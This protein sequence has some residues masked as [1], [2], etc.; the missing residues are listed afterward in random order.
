MMVA[1]LTMA[2]SLTA[3]TEAKKE[4]KS[5]S[6]NLVEK[7]KIV[8]TICI[9]TMGTVKK[10]LL[11]AMID[12]IR[13]HYPKCRFVKN[14]PLPKSAITK[15]RNDHVRYISN[16]LN[17]YLAQYKSDTTIV[18]GLT[19][20]DIGKD[21]FRNRPHS[22][23]MGEAGGFNVPVAVFSSYRPKNNKQLFSVILHEVGHTQ[24]LRHC[25]NTKCMMQNAN[26]GNPFAKTNHF[27][28]KCKK[29]MQNRGWKL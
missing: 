2:L 1:I 14:I 21:N 6:Q 9:Y 8:P 22:G 25:P 29:H 13:N 10:D 5:T 27:C 18:I 17:D 7:P 3:C 28:D 4:N 26:G 20:A 16:S 12:S 19:S 24:G 15:K 11:N 23:I